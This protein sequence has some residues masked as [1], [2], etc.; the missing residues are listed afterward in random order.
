MG[1]SAIEM[2]SLGASDTGTLLLIGDAPISVRSDV[3]VPLCSV[4]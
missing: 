3:T 2:Q 4:W 1:G